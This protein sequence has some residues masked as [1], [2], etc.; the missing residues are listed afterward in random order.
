MHYS[1]IL[2]ILSIVYVNYKKIGDQIRR[3]PNKASVI[4]KILSTPFLKK[5]SKACRKEMRC[6][7][8]STRKFQSRS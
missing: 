8:V 7:L 5:K 6:G 3:G 2:E 4:E 1:K